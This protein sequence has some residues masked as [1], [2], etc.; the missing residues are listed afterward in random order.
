V[1]YRFLEIT[2][3]GS[4]VTMGSQQEIDRPAL[5]AFKCA[6]QGWIQGLLQEPARD[7]SRARRRRSRSFGVIKKIVSTSSIDGQEADFILDKLAIIYKK[8]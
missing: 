5:Q 1:V 8:I 7:L 2:L 6:C 3:R 4:L